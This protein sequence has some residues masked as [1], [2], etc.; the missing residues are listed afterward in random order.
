MPSMIVWGIAFTISIVVMVLTAGAR[1]PMLHLLIAALICLGIAFVGILENQKLRR[2]GASK[3]E[4]AAATARN[5]GFI[6]VWGAAIIA[7]TYMTIL[8]WH[9]WWHWFLGFALVG[10]ACIFY[11][12]AITRDSEQGKVDDTLL[13]IGNKLTW[14]QL[15]G[16]II[17]II[18]M[19]VDGKLTRYLNPK[20]MDWAAQNTFFTGA[21]GLAVLSA[22]ALWAS[23]DD[24]RKAAA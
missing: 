11:S 16:M 8:N 19:L 6:Y 21:V 17:A 10:T 5:M 20:L 24:N 9:E 23:R 3:A 4:I 14:L 12:N 2:E 1:M 18:G 22:Y 15:V 13:S 7:L